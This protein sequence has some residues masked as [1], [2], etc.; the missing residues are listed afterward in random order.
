VEERAKKFATTIGST[1]VR[2]FTWNNM[3]PL[4]ISKD[5]VDKEC[6]ELNPNVEKAPF[7]KLKGEVGG[8]RFAGGRHHHRAM[9]ILREKSKDVVTG[10]RDKLSEARRM[11]EGTE[12]GGKKHEKLQAR[13]KDLLQTLEVEKEVEM[14]L[15]VWGIVLYDEGECNHV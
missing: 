12:A 8:L 13:I 11:L 7:L 9:E 6:Y 3:L 10:L 14:N 1:N 2:P 4:V 15:S 5:N